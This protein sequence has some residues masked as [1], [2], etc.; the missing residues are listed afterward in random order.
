MH[1]FCGRIAK[2]NHNQLIKI[3]MLRNSKYD[4]SVIEKN[5]ELQISLKMIIVDRKEI[6]TTRTLNNQNVYV[7]IYVRDFDYY[8]DD[9]N[10][11]ILMSEQ[12]IQYI[13]GARRNFGHGT[14]H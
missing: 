4:E 11:H 10:N 14:I 9:D 1:A 6:L 2:V 5:I 12:L 13:R 7:F 8:S 3:L